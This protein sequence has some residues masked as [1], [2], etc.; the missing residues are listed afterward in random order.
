MLSRWA[1]WAEGDC[2]GRESNRT[3]ERA[4]CGVGDRRTAGTA[5][6][7]QWIELTFEPRTVYNQGFVGPD[8]I[9]VV[10]ERSGQEAMTLRASPP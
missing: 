8:E 1:C 7:E 5:G 4:E 3:L 2:D 10:Q 6:Q 9:L